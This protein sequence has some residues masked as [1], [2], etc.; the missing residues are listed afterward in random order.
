M[1]KIHHRQVYIMNT[2]Y[3]VMNW[4]YDETDV[5][6]VFSTLRK[7]EEYILNNRVIN[8]EKRHLTIQTWEVL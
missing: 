6:A 2:V 1:P 5:V 7:A 8:G 4:N 3:L